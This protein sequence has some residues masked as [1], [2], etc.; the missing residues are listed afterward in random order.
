MNP[1]RPFA[2]LDLPLIGTTV[3]LIAV[4]VLSIASATFGSGQSGLWKM[5]LL[6]LMVALIAALVIVLVDYRVWAEV[7]LAM[8]GVVIAL[9]VAVLF[10][11]REV[12]GNRSWL[13]FG[14]MRLQPSE[15]AKWTTCLVLAVYLARR[16]RGGMGLRQL[17]EIG[18]LV[19]A[20]VGLISLQPDMGTALTFIPI[21]MV[22]L[23]IGG[24]RW[25]VMFGLAIVAMLMTPIAWTQLRPYQKERI[26]TVF[27][28]ERDPH[29]I[30]YQVRQ[31]KIAIG[32]GQI[33]GSGP[34]NGTQSQLNFLPAQHTDFVLSV[35]AE[36]W[37]FVGASA[38]LGLFYYLFYRC[39]LAARSA[40]DRL[41]TYVCLLVV[42]WIT[43]QMVINIGMVLG[44]LPTIGVPLPLVSYGGSALIAALSGIALV[45]NVRSRRFVN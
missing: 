13:D 29:R 22:G 19:G 6:W 20:P 16:V 28:A 7:A 30:G 39:I 3:A 34:F 35:F 2:S 5:Q 21:L 43:G 12:G 17:V 15:L 8:H 37:G 4:G 18:L 32:S 27:D 44:R 23:L 1:Q 40:Q 41:G 25:R 14:P 42:A 26:L 36:E 10:F 9:L 31:S 24:I 45:V 11:G 33:V 38:V